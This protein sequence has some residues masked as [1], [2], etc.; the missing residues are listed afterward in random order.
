MM[1]LPTP[2]GRLTLNRSLADLTW[3]RVGGAA[4]AVFQ[5]SD[6]Q[7][8]AEFLAQLPPDK[9]I[10]PRGVGSNLVH[11]AGGSRASVLRLGR[12]VYAI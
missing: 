9:S 7:D 3:L 11:R 1:T 8:L 10:C 5:P 2:R 12:G 4:D 6:R